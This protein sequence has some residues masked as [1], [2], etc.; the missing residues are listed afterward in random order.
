MSLGQDRPRFSPDVA[1]GLRRQLEEALGPVGGALG[2][3]LWVTKRTLG[4]VHSCEGYYRSEQDEPFGWN[5]RN[6]EGTV[7]HRAL[8]LAISARGDPAPLDLV[9]RALESL[10]ADEHRTSLR[11]WLMAADELDVAELRA[12]V[13]DTV[14]KFR[15]CWPP[16]APAWSPRTETSIGADLC[17]GR[18]VL[19]GR[20]DLVLG[21]A[22]GD[23]ARC[24]I[25]D[26]KT[27]RANPSH[28]EDLRFYALVQTLRVG[29]PPFRVASYYLDTASFH[30]ED[31]DLDTLEAAVRRTI[32][33][34]TKLAR[35]A[36][37][38]ETATLTP[39]PTCG[40]CGLAP[41]CPAADGPGDDELRL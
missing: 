28:V 9:D 33:G 23:E 6:A 12:R 27:G 19:R 22:R 8:E 15:E 1:A 14:V 35:L 31:V 26:L 21:I 20:V 34:V 10:A 30:A 7:V 13:N 5:S 37:K 38:A 4:Q 17:S 32:D 2:E 40:W 3:P 39:G 25:V 18:I 36:D 41:S 11:P 29:V 16:L 24:L